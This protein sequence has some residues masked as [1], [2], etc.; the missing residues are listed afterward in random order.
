MHVAETRTSRPA[1]HGDEAS[2]CEAIDALLRASRWIVALAARS[3]VD[4]DPEI[5][6]PQYRVLV[7]LEDSSPR[8]VTELAQA[9][10]VSASTTTRMCDRLVRKHLVERSAS[11]AD[12]RRVDLVL[13][14]AGREVIDR[15]TTRRREALVEGLRA[16]TP[17]ERARLARALDALLSAVGAR[18][19][20]GSPAEPHGTP[21]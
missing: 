3:L 13:A 8:S 4:L 11:A 12:R 16:L 17:V 7:L 2:L 20:A 1:P 21:R 15:V 14:P 9:L 5:T 18:E 10:G 6:F 19:A